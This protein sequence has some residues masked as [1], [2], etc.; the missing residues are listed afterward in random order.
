MKRI[1]S[2]LLAA[3]ACTL[4]LLV[5]PISAHAGDEPPLV[6]NVARTGPG[7]C[8]ARS[9]TQLELRRASDLDPAARQAG[10]TVDR[11]G[12]GL[13]CVDPGAFVNLW[14]AY[15]DDT[16]VSSDWWPPYMACPNTYWLL[17][18]GAFFDPADPLEAFDDNH[19]RFICKRY[20][21]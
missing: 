13:I 5:V 17:S 7:A 4:A 2:A 19:D 21:I 11:N 15:V 8:P 10:T 20:P 9:G 12:D 16:I 18:L 3:A 14:P 6:D 1:A